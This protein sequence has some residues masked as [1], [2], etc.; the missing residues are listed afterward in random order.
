MTTYDWLL[1][2]HVTGA[3][4]LIG[5][6]VCAGWLTFLA[7]RRERPSEIATLLG[8]VR[9][10]LPLMFAGVVLTLVFG[11]WLV[12][13]ANQGYGY[14]DAWVIA[15]L[16][17]WVLANALGQVGGKREK[18]T[19]EL[20]ARLASEGDVASEDLRARLRDPATLALSFGSGVIVFVILVL[21]IWKPGS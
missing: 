18:E 16:I 7:R 3:F 20:A 8:L 5:A 6:T 15:A 12:R 1:F 13:A 9:V 4:F 10:V 17:L 19:Q 11:L 2:F 14:D 21:M